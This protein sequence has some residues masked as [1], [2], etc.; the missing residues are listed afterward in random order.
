[1]KLNNDILHQIEFNGERFIPGQVDGDIELEHIHRYLLA[2]ELATDK[3]VLDIASG[4]GYG[5]AMLARHATSV[6]GVDISSDA[7]MY[8]KTKFSQHNL[9]FVVGS[10]TSIPLTDGSIDLVVSF[11]TI[12]HL[13]DHEEM[14]CE[15]KRVLKPDGLLIISSPDRFEYSDKPGYTNEFHVKELYKDEFSSLISR[16]FKHHSVYGQRVAFGSI[17]LREGGRG[18]IKS[19]VLDPDKL[20]HAVDGVPNALYHVAIASDV[21]LPDLCSGILDFPVTDSSVY[22]QLYQHSTRLEEATAELTETVNSLILERD[23]Y[24]NSVHNIEDRSKHQASEHIK[25]SED[26]SK[27]LAQLTETVNLVVSERDNYKKSVQ[28]VEERASCQASEYSLMLEELSR[29]SENEIRRLST[30]LS[31][32]GEGLGICKA[33]LAAVYASKSWRITAP[34][35]WIV[36][37]F[38][39]KASRDF[40]QISLKSEGVAFDKVVEH[41]SLGTEDIS[42][43]AKNSDRQS[44]YE[45]SSEQKINSRIL[46]VSYYCPTRAH[47][48]GLRILDIYRLIKK[49]YPAVHIDLLTHH[50]PAIDWSLDDVYEI[51][52][53]VY[54]SPVENLSPAVLKDLSGQHTPKYDVVD[55]QFHQSA[56]HLDGF[57]E[58]GSKILFTPMESQAK[59][60]FINLCKQ[61]NQQDRVPLR[62][63][64]KQF[65]PAYDEIVFCRK[66]DQAICV[67]KS[68]AAF[69]RAVGGGQYVH[70]IETGLSSLEFANAFDEDFVPVRAHEREKT[71]I[72]VAY[73]GS[74]TNVNALRWYLETVHPSVL[75]AVPDY[76]LKVVGRGDLSCFNSY[77]GS[78]IELVG[79]VPQLEPYIRKARLGIA[80]ALG[81]S[82]FRGKINQYSILGIPTVASSIAQK[83]LAYKHGKNILIAENPQGFAECCIRLLTDDTWN[84][85]MATEARKLCLEHY[86]WNS[87]WPQIC[88]AYGLQENCA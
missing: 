87:K 27:Q 61:I 79:E 8:A 18:S 74:E 29:Q 70:S 71:I 19:Y 33:E 26:L 37:L 64:I 6:V 39:G 58:I 1:M 65:K 15:I 13:S 21:D 62:Q 85:Q 23:A 66:A 17:V 73:F 72:Y 24:K 69:I 20:I 36:S 55:L 12:E 49:N 4:A 67:S 25:V 9:D 34:L 81:G 7:V 77:C 75:S 47:A 28:V 82:G 86:T 31:S 63:I 44:N 14:M 50:R 84:D 54:L 41:T 48:G 59:V 5:S 2:C 42:T 32:L 40:H 83:G 68:D 78:N 22:K 16:Y 10:C 88:E 60:L 30:D 51:F 57:R 11:E 45:C 52:D 35:R 53:N 3:A 46:L 43:L 76:Y 56:Y 80:P 38:A